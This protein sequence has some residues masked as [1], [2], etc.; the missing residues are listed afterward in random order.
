MI[1]F[2]DNLKTDVGTI[3]VVADEVGICKI[4]IT[5]EDW[6]MYNQ[7][8]Q[9]RRDEERCSSAI[10]QLRE[11]FCGQR[12]QFSIPLSIEGTAFCRQ[13]WRELSRIPYGQVRTYAA[14]AASIGRPK[15]YRAVGQANYLNLLPI[16]IPCHR[17]IGKN[18]KMTGYRGSIP[19][20]QYL[21]NL[22]GAITN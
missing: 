2:Y 18:G 14:I 17:V 20:K 19:M 3:Y 22:E 16:I 12:Q 15:A 8:H 10:R 4:A 7:Q 11:Y 5:D 13:V 6:Q 9:C 21:L 1:K